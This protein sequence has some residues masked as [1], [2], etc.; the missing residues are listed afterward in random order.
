[1]ITDANIGAGGKPGQYKFGKGIKLKN[2]GI[3]KE[4]FDADIVLINDK[5]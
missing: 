2:K 4:G 5:L 1:V 3:I